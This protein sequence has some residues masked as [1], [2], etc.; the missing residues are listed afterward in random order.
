M[1]VYNC[2]LEI[3]DQ[4]GAVDGPALFNGVL[5][6]IPMGAKLMQLYW[7][8]L[9]G[10]ENPFLRWYDTT[11][12]SFPGW[13]YLLKPAVVGPA[14]VDFGDSIQAG[15]VAVAANSVP[16]Q[17]A[18]LVN[19]TL[20]NLGVSG[21]MMCGT[22][23]GDFIPQIDAPATAAA[24]AAAGIIT[25]AYGTN[26]WNGAVPIGAETD[27]ANGTFYGAMAEGLGKIRTLNATGKIA[28]A[29]PIYRGKA[30]SNP[31]DWREAGAHGT[32]GLFV[33]DYRR[34]IRRFC[35]I[36]EI[37]VL[38]MSTHFAINEDSAPTYLPDCLHPN[39]AGAALM[40][41]WRVDQWIAWKWARHGDGR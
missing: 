36:N 19:G 35:A 25:V 4:G 24:I 27:T 11:S 38:E 3:D 8:T 41:A 34:A 32:S 9:K 13:R 6:C 26:D 30:Y 31:K 5:Q 20:T 33:E 29:V 17:A 15:V 22:E 39:I 16:A 18:A 2:P 28:F 7:D 40:A 12:G 10:A 37:P 21:R 14:L 23:V 1:L